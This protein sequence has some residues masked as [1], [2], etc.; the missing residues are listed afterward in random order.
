[1]SGS[2]NKV[3][4]SGVDIRVRL[5]RLAWLTGPPVKQSFW[6][7]T[8]LQDSLPFPGRFQKL[9]VEVA[10]G[11]EK[12]CTP[13]SNTFRAS[14]SRYQLFIQIKQIKPLP[15]KV[16]RLFCRWW[17]VPA[18]F[19]FRFYFFR[20][21]R[22]KRALLLTSWAVTLLHLVQITNAREYPLRLY[23]HWCV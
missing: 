2:W 7:N 6:G 9:I 18:L 1:M 16:W 22:W 19:H 11:V 10:K 21:E 4:S 12:T 23:S 3:R 14:G 13:K 5:Y 20:S 15:R 8:W 17:A